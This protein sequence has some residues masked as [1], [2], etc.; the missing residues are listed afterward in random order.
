VVHHFFLPH[1]HK[2]RHRK[3]HFLSTTAVAIYLS[4]FVFIQIGFASIKKT[5]PGVLGTTSNITKQQIIDLTNKEREK[6]GFPVLKENNLLDKAAEDKAKNMFEEDYWAHNSPKGET[7]WLWMKNEGYSY[8]YAGENLARG[9]YNSDDVVAA[10]MASKEGHKENLL[11]GNFTEIGVAAEDGILNGE[12]TTLVVQMFGNQTSA[13]AQNPEIENGAST[14]VS[15]KEVLGNSSII[16]KYIR[17]DQYRFTRTIA[18]SFIVLLCL[19]GVLD[20]YLIR[21]KNVNVNLYSRHAPHLSL[22]AGLIILLIIFK[23]GSIL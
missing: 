9:F 13:I 10:W 11:S 6:N 21:K 17:F 22:I 20:F 1:K 4:F 5:Q 23:A 14:E 19:L 2:K 16:S 8:V 3:A 15:N 18:L 7:P 12:K